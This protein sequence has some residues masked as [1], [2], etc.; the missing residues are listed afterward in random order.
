MTRPDPCARRSA[1]PDAPLRRYGASRLRCPARAGRCSL[2][3]PRVPRHLPRC[4]S[5]A[6]AAA[7]HARSGTAGS[8][9]FTSR[10]TRACRTRAARRR[11]ARRRRL[12]VLLSRSARLSGPDDPMCKGV[13]AM[14]AGPGSAREPRRSRARRRRGMAAPPCGENPLSRQPRHRL[15][16]AHS[17]ARVRSRARHGGDR[18]SAGP[19]RLPTAVRVATVDAIRAVVAL[20]GWRSTQPSARGA[21]TP[22][23]PASST[24]M[25]LVNRVVLS[26]GRRRVHAQPA[27]R[28]IAAR[29]TAKRPVG[30]DRRP[31]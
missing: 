25:A 27:A 24:T 10:V 4:G 16:H 19:L 11:T 2:P 30:I 26:P 6:T 18:P 14:R 31:R 28:D 29:I 8:P 21:L 17:R 12:S 1:W 20:A 22:P 3:C 5:M 15:D 9:P 7:I 13:S 23:Q